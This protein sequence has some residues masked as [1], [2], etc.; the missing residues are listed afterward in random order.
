MGT[1]K[2]IS[3]HLSA[4]GVGSRDS[5]STNILTPFRAVERATGAMDRSWVNVYNTA[6]DIVGEEGGKRMWEEDGGNTVMGRA[7]CQV[8]S[9]KKLVSLGSTKLKASVSRAGI[10][11]R[12][13]ALRSFPG[14]PD[15]RACPCGWDSPPEYDFLVQG[16]RFLGPLLDA[17][18]G[19]II[20]LEEFLSPGSW[21]QVYFFFHRIRQRKAA[22]FER[23]EDTG[24]VSTAFRI[25][26]PESS[27]G[28]AVYANCQLYRDNKLRPITRFPSFQSPPT[29]QTAAEQYGKCETRPRFDSESH[30]ASP[31]HHQR[32]HGILRTASTHY[33][34]NIACAYAPTAARRPSQFV[35]FEILSIDNLIYA[36][37]KIHFDFPHVVARST[38]PP[39]WS[40]SPQPLFDESAVPHP[41]AFTE[42]DAGY[43]SARGPLSQCFVAQNAKMQRKHRTRGL[44]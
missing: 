31:T 16:L 7:I 17:L 3:A 11:Y 36:I 25:P 20:I 37:L 44:I 42:L 15:V 6:R 29:S 18:D 41:P 28:V 35:W 27:S 2:V 14:K 24:A 5:A 12:N 21:E 4:Q 38:F 26:Y 39:R 13:L 30:C 22:N 43:V 34:P 19:A 32:I 1:F 10:P 9:H 40:R 8:G 33:Q 23:L